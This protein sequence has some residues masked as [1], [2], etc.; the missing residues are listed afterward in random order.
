MSERHSLRIARIS[1]SAF[2]YQSRPDR[3][4][5]LQREIVRLAHRHKRYGAS[6]IGLKLRQSGWR[7]NHKRVERLYALSGLPVKRRKR[8][9]VPTC[10][11]QP[12][13]RPQQANEVWSMD[14]V[15]DRTA[16]GQV[17]ERTLVCL[18]GTRQNDH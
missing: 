8:K 5:E 4:I 13:L 6:M 18:L 10:D 9:K 14:F 12:L 3:N 7:V 11:R 17:P 15:F 2:R 1:A 16:D